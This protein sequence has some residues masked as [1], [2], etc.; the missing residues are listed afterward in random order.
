[1]ADA[2]LS[3]RRQK[4]GSVRLYA[5]ISGWDK[6][7]R[8]STKKSQIYIGGK[9]AD[10]TYHFN[11]NTEKYLYLLR[12]TEFERPFYHWQDYV[13]ASQ[14]P[15]ND[16]DPFIAKIARCTDLCG[17]IDLLLG[18][19][20]KDLMLDRLLENVFGAELTDK[21][22]TLAYYCA[23]QSRNP[24]YAAA[25][26]S[27]NQ[28]LPIVDPFTEE[29]ISQLL[30]DVKASE[31]LTF[32]QS[33]IKHTPVDHRLSL[34]ITSVSSYSKNNPDVMPGYNR[35]HEKLPQ[36]N[37]LMMVDQ[38]TKLPIWYE[39]LPGAVADITT[40]KDTVHI[41]SQMGVESRKFVYDRGF[42]SKDNIA[43]LQKNHFKFTMGIPM[44]RKGFEDVLTMLSKIK[45]NHEFSLPNIST[46]L[47][48]VAGSY[49]SQ[50][51]T[52]RVNW[53]GHRVYLHFFYC[54]DYKTN[55]E[56]DLMERVD[57]V[58]A[59]LKAG[60]KPLTDLDMKIAEKCFTVTKPNRYI[61]VE[62]NPA[63][64]DELKSECGGYFVLCSNELKDFRE[65][66][67]V[68]KLRDGVEKQ[69][70]DLKN[71]EDCS[72]L[73]VHSAE[74]MRSR[75]F[76][77]F[78]AQILRCRLLHAKQTHID[79]WKALKISC[80]TVSDIMRAMASLRYIRIDSHHPFYKRPTRTQ[81]ALLKFFGVPTNSQLWWPSLGRTQTAQQDTFK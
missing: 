16:S 52:K 17:G 53:N 30:S 14:T 10:G 63:A 56:K 41:L 31:I 51:V 67:Y 60:K 27:E 70:D 72:R 5:V 28:L 24:L 9:R 26:W 61:V 43:Y 32:L 11:A 66:L 77:Q 73:R 35:D 25:Q 79:Q 78:L 57:A 4:D 62:C 1:M 65:A 75:L 20:A 8:K 76:I 44:Y 2:H 71:D 49:K 50:A 46:D 33:W 34:D 23:S 22:L 18:H 80:K 7:T 74:R 3:I 15:Q 29:Q 38:Q 48:D 13:Q 58:N 37:L 40:V 21:L 39:Q 64:V 19:I 59:M 69:F 6:E 54:A 68:Y 81:L 55:N 42:A 12:G 45:A 36:I 47:F